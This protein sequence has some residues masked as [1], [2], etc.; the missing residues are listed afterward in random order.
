MSSLGD[1]LKSRRSG[2]KARIE[3]LAGNKTRA[4]GALRSCGLFVSSATSQAAYGDSYSLFGRMRQAGEALPPDF[5]SVDEYTDLKG[6]DRRVGPYIR[7]QLFVALIAE[8]E[9][10]FFQLLQFVL[11]AFPQKIGDRNLKLGQLLELGTLEVVISSAAE[12]FLI[13]VFYKGP[14]DQRN[15]IEEVLSMPATVLQPFWPQYIEMKA[16]RDVGLHNGWRR[17][18]VYRRK[19]QEAGASVPKS[20]F[21]AIDRKYF[22][23]S[24]AVA[25]KLVSQVALHCITKFGSAA[26]DT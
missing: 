7:S 25:E 6:P 5:E 23:E 14:I 18:E 15:H 16:R 26:S 17:N 2:L 13:G 4:I 12:D 8:L 3:T 11:E 24:V 9:D 19:V 10:F 20:V 1:I 22:E 21:L